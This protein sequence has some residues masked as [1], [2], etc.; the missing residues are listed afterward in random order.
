MGI[1][2]TT[3]LFLVIN[4]WTGEKTSLGK[5]D[6]ASERIANFGGHAG[7]KR[8][9]AGEPCRDDFGTRSGADPGPLAFDDAVGHVLQHDDHL[10]S[11]ASDAGVFSSVRALR[12]MTPRFK[13]L[14]AINNRAL[15]AIDSQPIHGNVGRVDYPEKV[16]NP[17]DFAAREP[18]VDDEVVLLGIVGS[19]TAAKSITMHL[20]NVTHEPSQQVYRV[21]CTPQY[22]VL[23][24]AR[25]PGG[26][27]IYRTKVVDV[28][29]LGHK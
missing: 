27:T 4:L 28:V 10:A 24:H 14:L 8:L 22:K 17:S 15:R 7:T 12:Q 26:G 11:M 25:P 1:T 18:N 5:S 9:P 20:V 23:R 29:S 6:R 19:N 13:A 16:G 3:M 21:A 2:L